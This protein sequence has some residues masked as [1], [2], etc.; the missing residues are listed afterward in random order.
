M[1]LTVALMICWI[2]LLAHFK[3]W[4]A[5]TIGTIVFSLILIG[6]SV[7]LV[8]TIKQVRINQM[9]AN[10]VDSVTHELKTPL[11]SIRLYLETLQMRDVDAEQR[12]EFYSVMGRELV[13]LDHLIN[14]LLE[15]GR[16]DAIGQHIASEDVSLEPLLRKIA[17]TTCD[18]Q[19][20]DFN[21]VISFDLQPAIVYARPIILE[22]IFGNLLDNA[23]KYAAAEPLVHITMS[24]RTIREEEKVVIQIQDN[25]EGIPVDIRNKIFRIFYRAGSE[26]KRKTKGTGLGLYIVRSLVHFMEGEVRVADSPSQTGSL[27]EVELPGRSEPCES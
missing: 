23:V 14:Q 6:L 21:R 18:Y 19:R 11:A 10:F 3:F 16:L 25:G 15:V 26:L 5:L 2:V 9:Q 27:F 12:N 8:L 22:M 4:T 20:C 24:V 13:R 7:Y 17:R 1:L